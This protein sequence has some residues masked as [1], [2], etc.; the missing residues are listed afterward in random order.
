MNFDDFEKRLQRQ[1]L[2][3]PPAAWRGEIIAAAQAAAVAESRHGGRRTA[4]SHALEGPSS[5]TLW[6]TFTALL[7]PAPVAWAGL[8]VIWFA[9]LAVNHWSIGGSR[10]YARRAS[11]PDSR[12]IHAWK[13]QEQI[14]VELIGPSKSPVA[15]PP[16]PA[17][18]RPHSERA[19]D[20][21]MA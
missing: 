3:P 12:M 8:V 7:W 10:T 18:P 2:R 13:E 20:W 1:P 19:T 21:L 5:P 14:L 15:D 4:H 6:Q 16:K 11:R 17:A 9:I